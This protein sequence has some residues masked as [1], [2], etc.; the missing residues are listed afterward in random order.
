MGLFGNRVCVCERCG[1][2]YKRKLFDDYGYCATC[3]PIAL[4]ER[5]EII[6]T[7]KGYQLYACDFLG[8]GYTNDELKEI[9]N[10]RNEIFNKIRQDIF[11]TRDDLRSACE[12]MEKLSDE[13]A[14][15]IAVRYEKEMVQGMGGCVFGSHFF[16]PTNY[17]GMIVDADDV[18]AIGYE[19]SSDESG[20]G[21]ETMVYT[22]FTNDKYA[23]VISISFPLKKKLFHTK[24]E[25]GRALVEQILTDM[26]P[27]LKYPVSDAKQLRKM[28]KNDGIVKGN[29]DYDNMMTML[30]WAEYCACVSDAKNRPFEVNMTTVEMLESAGYLP[31]CVIDSILKKQFMTQQMFWEDKEARAKALMNGN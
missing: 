24:S 4:A 22:I 6:A 23:P 20:N 30:K 27:N 18:F 29:I 26:C 16:A 7:I 3:E 1:K 2:E 19:S 28:I 15:H 11:I 9:V 21:I 31:D 10:H 25:E 14:V 13:E 8:G 12:N 17:E 5:K